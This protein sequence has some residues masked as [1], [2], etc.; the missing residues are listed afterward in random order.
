MTDVENTPI[1]IRPATHKDKP[2][3]LSLFYEFFEEMKET[4]SHFPEVA[5]FE[6]V[7]NVPS[8]VE[9]DINEYIDDY[10]IFVATEKDRLVG[11]ISGEVFKE[12]Y[13][14]LDKEGFIEDW[15]ITKNYRGKGIGKQLFA[16]LMGIFS[17][18]NCTHLGV[19]AFWDHKDAVNMYE[20]MGFVK[21]SV[22]FK[23]LI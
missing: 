5:V 22:N 6:S 21:H 7:R 19:E 2:Q 1:I 3:L 20:K 14:E 18:K 15:Y 4:H 23:K 12:N 9:E 8:F 11:Y 10:Y 17:S 16:K 13:M